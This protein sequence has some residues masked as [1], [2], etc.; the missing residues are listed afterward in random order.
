VNKT[1]G[2]VVRSHSEQALQLATHVQAL[3]PQVRWLLESEGRYAL[4]E[5]L[6]GMVRVCASDFEA[7]SDMLLALGGDGTLLHA[8][9]LLQT[10]CVPIL[11]VNLGRIGFL[12]EVHPQDLPDVLPKALQGQLPYS[13]RVRLDVDV[14]RG[15]HTCLLRRRVL[16]DAVVS[17]KALARVGAY[18]VFHNGLFV[19][20]VRGDGLI[21][22]TPTG[23][24][25]YALAA[26]GSI[27]VPWL[28]AVTL[29][30][31]CPHQLTQRPLVVQA[32]G[33]FDIT[34]EDQHTAWVTLDG[35][36]GEEMQQGDVLRIQRAP[37]GTRILSLPTQNYYHTLR[38]KLRWGEG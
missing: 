36:V 24:T 22:S 5:A 28:D 7:Q 21:V 38:T 30:P 12:A 6:P 11:G 25:A 10:R 18:Q 19:T 3:F 35:Q 15:G 4:G 14:L 8:A 23:S 13:D 27:V 37:L 20:T 32:E 16:N 31:I 29:T 17:L 26:G 2:L 34:L 1:V 33:V 9:S